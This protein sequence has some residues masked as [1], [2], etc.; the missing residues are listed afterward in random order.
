M[1]LLRNDYEE[2]LQHLLKVGLLSSNPLSDNLAA[3]PLGTPLA[4]KNGPRDV[5]SNHHQSLDP[6]RLGIGSQRRQSKELTSNGGPSQPLS[7]RARSDSRTNM[8]SKNAA[9]TL[10]HRTA[11]SAFSLSSLGPALNDQRLQ[12][13][14]Q[15]VRTLD[16]NTAATSEEKFPRMERVYALNNT[17]N[18]QKPCKSPSATQT[19]F[20]SLLAFTSLED[21]PRLT[22]T[23]T[24]LLNKPT[25]VFI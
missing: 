10:A 5:T 8:I 20:P 14:D 11:S 16:Y 12:S 6:I 1:P 7:K 15:K 19:Q 25:K 3:D 24:N 9:V 2:G 23:Q 21:P 4:Q 17:D 18:N 13:L 22:H